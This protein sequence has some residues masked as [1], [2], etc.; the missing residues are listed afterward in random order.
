MTEQE[1]RDLLLVAFEYTYAH[2]DW[3]YPLT[4]ALES[5]A[6]DQAAWRPAPDAAG[7]ESMGIWDIVL[8]LAVWNNNIVE[9]IESGE[10]AHPTEGAWP[11]KPEVLD[12]RAWED[13]QDKL[14]AS[15][16]SVKNLIE[17]V[18]FEKIESSPYGF[19]D[20]LCRFTHLAYHIG[21]IVKIR[22]CQEW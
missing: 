3:S 8:H 13:A 19:P 20:L 7:T 4:E 16:E 22:E 15:I 12:E 11:A 1:L 9:R 17:K 14:W 18:P 10:T 2:D 5:I 6:A 21:Q